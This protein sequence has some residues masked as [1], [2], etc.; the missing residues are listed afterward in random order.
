LL[1]S[2]GIRSLHPEHIIGKFKKI[3]TENI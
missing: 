2:G 1:F 3:L